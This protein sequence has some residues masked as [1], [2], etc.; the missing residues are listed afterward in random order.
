MSSTLWQSVLG[1]IEVST[2][3]ASFATWFKNTALLSNKN[4]DVTVGVPNIFT[5]RQFEAKFKELISNTLSRHGIDVRSL[6]FQVRPL[7]NPV[8]QD[9]R[10]APTTTAPQPGPAANVRSNYGNLNG[11]YTFDS[12]VVG[13][14]NELAY[15]ACQVIAREPSEK[16]NPL[17]VYGGGR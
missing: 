1:E 5:K 11:R 14:S 2:S 16:Y 6:N 3:P 12:F 4:G 13:S 10:P 8:S 17:F 15:A 9:I 7:N